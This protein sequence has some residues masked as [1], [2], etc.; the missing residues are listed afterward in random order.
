MSTI[1]SSTPTN[2]AEP[3]SASPQR[4]PR[5]TVVIH[6]APDRPAASVT[7][8]VR[9]LK[10][11]PAAQ[12]QPTEESPAKRNAGKHRMEEPTW[13]GLLERVLYSWP[14]TLRVALLVVVVLTGTAAVAA[15]IG[16][17]G[18]LLLAALGLR[19]RRNGR[20]QATAERNMQVSPGDGTR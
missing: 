10:P 8:A 6:N 17:G 14:I 5:I 1:D 15:T 13:L 20:R 16:I 2:P 12:S 7:P 4:A 19:A 18:Q 3:L 9:L 11:V